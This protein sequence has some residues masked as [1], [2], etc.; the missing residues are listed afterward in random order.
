MIR[1]VVADD[2]ELVRDGLVAI[3]SSAED[4]E[5]VGTAATGAEAVR[6]AIDC[7]PDVVLMDIR[8][9]EMDGIEAT[10]QLIAA[11]S[12]A[13]VLVLTTVELDDVVYAALD[14]GASGFLLKSVPRTQLWSGLRSVAGGDALLAPS[15]TR[16]LIEKHLAAGPAVGDG[17]TLGLSER[18]AEVVRLVARGMTNHEIAGELHLAE[19][20]VKGYV[21]DQ[22]ARYGL[23]DRT[24][25]VILAYESGL[26]R[27][28]GP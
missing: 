27:P 13:K 20:T 23:R 8:M 21:S 2:E 3:V 6:V 24:Q 7:D 17:T 26:V 1:V 9:P 25:L 15:I 11:G 22:L 10:R 16:R 12:R 19:S 5:V 14:A 28:S 18:Q 4:L